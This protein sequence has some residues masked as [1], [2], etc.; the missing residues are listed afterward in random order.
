MGNLQTH[1]I[2][3]RVISTRLLSRPGLLAATQRGYVV[4]SAYRTMGVLNRFFARALTMK[5]ATYS[6]SNG[7]RRWFK[8]WAFRS[9]LWGP[10][11]QASKAMSF[12]KVLTLTM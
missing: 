5:M 7:T 12:R 2:H 1:M 11:L 9:L 3:L 4:H 10:R 8:F 6:L